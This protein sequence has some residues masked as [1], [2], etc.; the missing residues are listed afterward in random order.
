MKAL[1]K[2]K[3]TYTPNLEYEGINPDDSKEVAR[4][5]MRINDFITTYQLED[6]YCEQYPTLDD[7][8]NQYN[9]MKL[10]LLNK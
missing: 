10:I 3:P 4:L 6:H 1:D 5:K 9:E 7:L 2:L 8:R